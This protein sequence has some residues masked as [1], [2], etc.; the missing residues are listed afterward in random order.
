MPRRLSGIVGART[1]ASAIDAIDNKALDLFNRLDGSLD[2]LRTDATS[3]TTS[4]RDA[5]EAMV[6]RA[7]M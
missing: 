1:I 4:I 7:Q 6:R 2:D 5:L 3:R